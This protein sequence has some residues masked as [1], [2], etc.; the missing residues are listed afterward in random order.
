MV[1][2][3]IFDL[4][5]LGLEPTTD[6]IICITLKNTETNEII[7]ILNEDE[8]IMLESFWENIKDCDSLIGFNSDTFDIPYLIKRSIINNVKITKQLKDIKLIDLR[9]IVN[10]FDLNPN[11]YIKGSLRFWA[12]IMNIKVETE[13]GEH[14]PLYWSNKEFDKIKQHN[15]EDV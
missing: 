15:E 10:C 9:K 5:T 2:N 13:N 6:R 3:Y 8:K 1:L 12:G 11:I 7:S 4:E 14:M